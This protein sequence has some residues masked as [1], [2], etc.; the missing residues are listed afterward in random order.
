DGITIKAASNRISYQKG[1]A[2]CQADGKGLCTSKTICK[3]NKTPYSGPLSGDHWVPVKDSYNEW[4]QIGKAPH[5]PCTLHSQLGSKPKWGMTTSSHS[6]KG[7][8]F[9]CKK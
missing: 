6:F 3:D 8:L 4:L 1:L 9:C 5:K 7:I 2:K